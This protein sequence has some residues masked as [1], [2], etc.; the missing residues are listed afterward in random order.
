MGKEPK[1]A[2][3]MAFSRAT[4]CIQYSHARWMLD[5]DTSQ[6]SEQYNDTTNHTSNIR[7]AI[8]RLSKF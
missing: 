8:M 5:M 2:C 7:Q 1:E 3:I 6:K 4:R